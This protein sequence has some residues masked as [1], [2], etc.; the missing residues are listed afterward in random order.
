MPALLL[1]FFLGALCAPVLMRRGRL[2]FIFLAGIPG[3]ALL[4]FLMELPGAFHGEVYARKVAWLPQLGFTFDVRIDALS[5]IMAL[6]VTG[7]GTLVLLYSARYF[8]SSA[9]HLGRFAGVFLAFAGAMLGLV[10]TDSTPALYLFWEL[11]T[12]FSFL[13][14]GH[15]SDRTSSRRAAQQAI[16]VTTVGGLAMLV[17]IVML[18]EMPGGSYS[19]SG[20]LASASAGTLGQGTPELLRQPSY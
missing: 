6:L 19:F 18:G 14:I 15:Y 12:V 2:G 10:T 4:W 7:V 13:L 3:I 5:L 9:A 17:G 1:L 8:S 16:I 20:L 11:T